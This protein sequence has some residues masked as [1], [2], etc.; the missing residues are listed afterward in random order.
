MNLHKMMPTGRVLLLW[1]L[2]IPNVA[3]F[4]QTVSIEDILNQPLIFIP[5][6]DTVGFGTYELAIRFPYGSPRIL[7]S[8][9]Y[10]EI[11]SYGK[12][13]VEYIY[14]KYTL[15]QP[16]QKKLD[17]ARFY[18]LKK[19]A[20]DLFDDPYIQWNITVQDAAITADSAR[21]LFHGF[22]IRYQ[23][24]ITEERKEEIKT[25]L[26][27][28]I[29][30]A[31]K[32][33]PADAPVFPGGQDSLKSW[34]AGHIP[35]PT[36]FN[37]RGS[38]KAAVIEFRIDTAYGT[39]INIQAKRGVSVKHNKA[40]EEAITRLKGWEKGN[41]DVVFTLLIQFSVDQ[42]GRKTIESTPLRAYNPKTC[43]GLKSDS[44][45]MKVLTRNKDWKKMLVVEDVTGSMMPYLADLLL[46]NALKR[47]LENTS[48]FVF[49]NDGD[50][51]RRD[52]KVIGK[53]G[54][55]Y[56]AKPNNVDSLEM[57]MITAIAGGN[58]DDIPEN[59]I[60]AVLA[61]IA[62]C[63]DCGEVVLISDNRAVPRDLELVTKIGKPVHVILCGVSTAY[64]V[65]PAHLYIAWKTKGSLHTITEDI[66]KL[67]EMEEGESISVMGKKYK[68]LNGKF[69]TVSKL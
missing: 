42:G 58:G 1:L 30:C 66:T 15:S 57:T 56:H 64:P 53:T 69:V 21:N 9:D 31:K 8:K 47:N 27:G 5:Q 18:A 67:A 6:F 10:E 35:F 34:F 29:D 16:G 68:I 54:G 41:P 65:S 22:I 59:D 20:P 55:L 38:K 7:N 25:E 14:S 28:L 45:I 13:S 12:V 24:P 19:L 40:I 26:D 43:K 50:A 52:E 48:H 23:P 63:P 60:E 2:M 46:W 17:R 4:A 36:N 37:K 3:L 51:K 61:G 49:F 44:L 39:P 33:P 62:A 32:R 11:R